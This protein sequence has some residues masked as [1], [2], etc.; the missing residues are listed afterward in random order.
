[1]LQ[2]ALSPELVILIVTVTW[3]WVMQW[4]FMRLLSLVG[5]CKILMFSFCISVVLLPICFDLSGFAFVYL[6]YCI[7]ILY[8]FFLSF[9]M[10]SY[11][12]ITPVS[13]REWKCLLILQTYQISNVQDQVICG[14]EQSLP[15]CLVHVIAKIKWA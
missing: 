7:F 11:R 8:P 4:D 12:Q 10:C 9:L 15:S 14:L 1:M 6:F 3:N 13:R 2:V 5:W